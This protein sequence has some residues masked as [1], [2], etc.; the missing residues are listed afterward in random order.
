MVLDGCL[1]TLMKEGLVDVVSEDD[2]PTLNKNNSSNEEAKLIPTD[3]NEATDSNFGSGESIRCVCGVDEDDGFTIQCDSCLVW[4]H[5]DC[6]GIKRDAVPDVYMCEQ[7]RPVGEVSVT[8]G[9]AL[10]RD[11]KPGRPSKRKLVEMNVSAKTNLNFKPAAN[12]SKNYIRLPVRERILPS[13]RNLASEYFQARLWWP[14]I[15]LDSFGETNFEALNILGLPSNAPSTLLLRHEK[16]LDVRE[17][18]SRVRRSNSQYFH[19]P[20][21]RFAV[22]VAQDIDPGAFIGEYIGEI[23]HASLLKDVS[24]STTA[25][26]FVPDSV[27]FCGTAVE[28]SGLV[29]D[30]RMKGNFL[31]YL[32]RSCRPNCMVK[33]VCHPN[34]PPGSLTISFPHGDEIQD[35]SFEKKEFEVGVHWCLFALNTIKTGDELLLPIDYEDGNRI[36]RHECVCGNPELCLAPLFETYLSPLAR[37]PSDEELTEIVNSSTTGGKKKKVQSQVTHTSGGKASAETLGSSGSLD[38]V[39]KPP[40]VKMSREERKLQQYIEFIERMEHSA[41]RKHGRKGGSLGASLPSN[42]SSADHSLASSNGSRPSTPIN[43]FPDSVPNKSNAIFADDEEANVQ[44]D[45]DEVF[46]GHPSNEQGLGVKRRGRKIEKNLDPHSD[47]EKSTVKSVKSEEKANNDESDRDSLNNHVLGSVDDSS[48]PLLS[49]SFSLDPSSSTV[50]GPMMIVDGNRASF[51]PSPPKGSIPLKKWHSRSVMSGRLELK[52]P[53]KRKLEFQGNQIGMVEEI[54]FDKEKALHQLVKDEASDRS[55]CDQIVLED[56]KKDNELI[57]NEEYSEFGVFDGTKSKP[58][59]PHNFE[60]SKM[61]SDPP[62]Q[63]S[64]P[65]KKRLSLSDY[66]SRRRKSEAI[67]NVVKFGL[68]NDGFESAGTEFNSSRVQ[69]FSPPDMP[70]E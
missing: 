9:G 68:E 58:V 4:Q 50:L 59:S 7:C 69:E 11:K 45:D 46:F 21:N 13:L 6:V 2:W 61:Q 40:T 31:R 12:L 37:V 48:S 51:S 36:I 57:K 64:T 49:K 66:L 20:A 5:V 27:L 10:V 28:V 34:P 23:T 25:S 30:S 42:Q 56:V 29:V 35:K 18:R 24:M 33:I 3:D 26:D 1:V 52:S 16:A 19:G 38:S 44:I 65:T 47:W 22:Y 62:P 70:G 67:S 39:G 15:S 32:R 17:L 8:V 14:R 53:V 54:K 63:E 60:N 55:E 43:N 41:D